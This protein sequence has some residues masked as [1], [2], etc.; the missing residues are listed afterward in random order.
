MEF[1]RS[2]WQIW[3]SVLELHLRVTNSSVL[4]LEPS[5]MTMALQVEVFW[6]NL[7][8]AGASSLV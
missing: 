1:R 2:D 8:L 6:S 5:A 7:P 4:V 3:A